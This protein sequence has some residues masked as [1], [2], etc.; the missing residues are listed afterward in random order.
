MVPAVGVTGGYDGVGAAVL[1]CAYCRAM[2]GGR[3]AGVAALDLG[4]VAPDVVGGVDM[5]TTAALADGLPPFV[6]VVSL[7]KKSTQRSARF[8]LS[9]ALLASN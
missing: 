7:S 1:R 5:G 9:S 6:A 4:V 3:D 8:E 2:D